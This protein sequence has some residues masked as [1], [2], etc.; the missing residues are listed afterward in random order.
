MLFTITAHTNATITAHANATITIFA[1]T[2]TTDSPGLYI[3]S[4]YNGAKAR[5]NKNHT[6]K[7]LFYFILIFSQAS[8]SHDCDTGQWPQTTSPTQPYH[9]EGKEPITYNYSVFHFQ[10][11]IQ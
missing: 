11:G 7:F 3:F 6:S 10:C 9:P 4:L 5:F 2:D 8:N 1:D